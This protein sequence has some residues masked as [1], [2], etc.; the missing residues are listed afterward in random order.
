MMMMVRAD[1]C[2]WLKR[3]MSCPEL[4]CGMKELLRS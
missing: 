4:L 2:R 3:K 1:R